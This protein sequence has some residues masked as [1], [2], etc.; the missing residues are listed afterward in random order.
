MDEIDEMTKIFGKLTAENQARLLDQARLLLVVEETAKKA[1][2][3][4]SEIDN[5]YY[6]R[7]LSRV[8]RSV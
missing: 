3:S 6:E 4:E 5:E 8:R 2:D 7:I 1:C